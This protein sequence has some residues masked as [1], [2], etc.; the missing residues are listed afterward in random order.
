MEN[1]WWG[2]E[3]LGFLWGTAP[4]LQVLRLR[5]FL[6]LDSPT[7]SSSAPAIAFSSSSP[8]FS[9]PTTSPNHEITIVNAMNINCSARHTPWLN[10]FGKPSTA[11]TV[12]RPRIN[13]PIPW[14]KLK[15]F[16]LSF[17]AFMIAGLWLK[18]WLLKSKVL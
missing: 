11:T 16:C 8:H 15:K 13:Q 2:L 18:R 10:G 3:F 12:D 9:S 7:S 4:L 5:F 14:K 6:Q 1:T 17:S